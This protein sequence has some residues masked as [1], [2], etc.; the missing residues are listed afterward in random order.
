M[1]T[2]LKES[3]DWIFS[4][5]VCTVTK[6]NTCFQPFLSQ[7]T[8]PRKDI[9]KMTPFCAMMT[10]CSLNISI[11]TQCEILASAHKANK[12]EQAHIPFRT[13]LNY[14]RT[15]W[16]KWIG[17]IQFGHFER[18]QQHQ[19][20]TFQIIVLFL[21][22]VCRLSMVA[23]E[24]TKPPLEIW[25]GRMQQT[26]ARALIYVCPYNTF[27]MFY[28]LYVCNDLTK[29]KRNGNFDKLETLGKSEIYSHGA[30]LPQYN[31][32]KTVLEVEKVAQKIRTCIKRRSW[33]WAHS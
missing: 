2:E 4:L 5:S 29:S 1:T 27:F 17:V 24:R 19:V 13:Q 11:L 23:C 30:L 10:M 26:G 22:R 21:T 15:S 20:V 31:S 6:L 18:K 25:W 16:T 32:W 8:P 14:N 12:E 9:T 7:G 3:W 33:A 28:G